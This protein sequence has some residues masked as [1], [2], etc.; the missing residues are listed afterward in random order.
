MCT[1]A[2]RENEDWGG[3]GGKYTS[4]VV[5]SVELYWRLLNR[6]VFGFKDEKEQI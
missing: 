1:T 3:M 5:A 6:H 4:S 2:I